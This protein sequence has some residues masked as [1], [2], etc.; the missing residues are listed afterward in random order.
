MSPRRVIAKMI[1]EL[2]IERNIITKE[3]LNIALEEQRK[4]GGYLSQHLIA[5]GFANELDIANCLA[6]QYDFAYLPLAH[7]DI[8]PR[9]LGTIPLRLIDI[10]SIFPVDKMGKVLSI[11]MADPLN[12][13]VIDML[14]QITECDIAV[15]ISTYSEIRK[16]IDKYFGRRLKE[17]NSQVNEERVKLKE[18]FVRQFVQTVN[19]EGIERRRS[20]RVNVEL[21]MTYFLQDKVLKVKTKNISLNGILFTSDLYIPLDKNIYTNIVC[22]VSL[23]DIIINSVVQIIR[24]EKIKD[25]E[26]VDS[27]GMIHGEYNI[28]GFFNF[29][30]DEDKN[31]LIEFLNEKLRTG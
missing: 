10:F 26:Q 28:A 3:E 23:K 31:K 17:V 16:A 7:Y 21:E 1:G 24:V 4:R 8:N 2:L 13:G 12:D 18:D 5:L 27:R 30:T 11:A 19:Y 14:K 15:F 29:M 9:L 25:T 6:S 20:K 22:K